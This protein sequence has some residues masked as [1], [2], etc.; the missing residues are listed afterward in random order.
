MRVSFIRGAESFA[1][2]E[3]PPE[4]SDMTT[5]LRQPAAILSFLVGDSVGVIIT[6]DSAN[7]TGFSPS[8]R[9]EEEQ[10]RTVGT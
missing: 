8:G 10:I 4:S 7:L 5:D 3:P 6:I 2:F 9:A 1:S